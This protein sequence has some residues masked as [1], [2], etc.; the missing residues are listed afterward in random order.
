MKNLLNSLQIKTSVK[1]LSNFFIIILFLFTSIKA[2]EE[3]VHI[4]HL[5]AEEGL[6]L[7]QV[8]QIYQ[9]NLGFMWLGTY[10][11]LNRYDGYNFKVFLPEPDNIKSISSHDITSIF[12]DSKGILWI[13]T[14][15][16]LN[17]YDFKTESFKRYLHDANDPNSLSNNNIYSIMEDKSGT[18]WFGT[19]DALNKYNRNKD[20]FSTLKIRIGDKLVKTSTYDNVESISCMLQDYKGNLWIGIWDG[21]INMDSN[22]NILKQFI[23][24]EG[25]TDAIGFKSIS[26]I[27]EDKEKFIWIGTNGNG[28]YKYD[29]STG[30]FDHYLSNDSDSKTISYNYIN[31]IFQDNY[32]DIWIGT[33]NGLNKY[34]PQNNTFIRIFNNSEKP[35]SIINNEILSITQDKSG[36]IWIGSNGGISRFYKPTN[37]FYY[38]QKD[39]RVTSYSLSNN[40]IN[41]VFID[42]KENMLVGTLDGLDYIINGEKHIINYRTDPHNKNSISDNYITTAIEDRSGYRWVGTYQNGLNRINLR[43]GE[44]KIFFH[45][46]EN[47][48]SLSNSGITDLLEDHK[49][50]IWVGTWYGLNRYNKSTEKFLRYENT[51]D[52]PK[53][54]SNNSV[55]KIYEDSKNMIWVGTDGGGVCMM[56][57][58]ISAFTVY[59]HDSTN[60][61][62]ISNNRVLTITETKDGLMW[63]GTSDGLNSF[64][65]QTGKFK[66]FKK[67]NGL[68]G[69]LIFSLQEDN[70]GLL[71]ISTDNGIS[72]YN[73]GTGTFTNYSKKD[74]LKELEFIG[75]ASC[76]AKDGTL[77]FG[78]KKG[79]LFFNPNNIVNRFAMAPIIFTDLKIYNKSVPIR[80]NSNSIL[81]ESITTSTSIEIPS[82][83][84]EI[85]IDFALLYYQSVRG[86]TYQYILSGFE[87]NWN[88]AGQRNSATYANL[89]PGEY[90]FQVQAAN[91]DGIKGKNVA[92]L[93]IIIVPAYYQTWWFKIFLSCVFLLSIG[94]FFQQRTRKIK[95][96]NKILE[97]HVAERTKDLDHT[98][99]ELNRE[100]VERKKAEANVHATLE[101]KEGLLLEKEILLKEIHHRV[102]NN[103]QIISSLLYLQS[104]KI[105]DS[106]LL[107]MFD[108]SLNRIKSMALLHEKLYQSNDLSEINLF[109]YINSLL[110][111]LKKSYSRSDI[112]IRDSI[113]I[114]HDI[115]F[116]LDTAMAC[117]LMI[118]ELM[119]NAYKYAFPK[120]WIEKLT[121]VFEFKIEV[122]V[123]KEEN[124]IYSLIVSDNGIGFPENFDIENAESLGMKIVSSMVK[125]LDGLLEIKREN[126][127]QFKTS[128]SY[129]K[130]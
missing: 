9:D 26:S 64:D 72:C 18:L 127:S 4:S 102:K 53:C 108:D 45:E 94:L 31:V 34:N 121:S 48:T 110:T 103:L 82:E 122:S 51:V 112:L 73:R 59:M 86:N 13:G 98:I 35:L 76:K 6:S 27:Y 92:S 1:Q 28:L 58:K 77:Y 78:S 95:S 100:V 39:N 25:N 44:N 84:G 104:R 125:Q 106:E 124:N 66:V 38:F 97:N 70:N 23:Y 21:L 46:N 8:T 49:G 79:L 75:R 119:T 33:K 22:G 30:K 113:F 24:K 87:K 63:F 89:P 68:P 29:P 123:V 11:G 17:R 56:D 19:H 52:D 3:E 90:I 115:N 111:H 36:L 14:N 67:E 32:N 15:N 91:S 50:T 71:W 65:R 88:D 74:G 83:S 40:R 114:N 54:L 101:E 80:Q 109:N 2:Q 10:S 107:N 57:P 43:T 16:G 128:F 130:K 99:T 118:N 85:T 37:K 96:Q 12:Q 60:S 55:W 105:K 93:Q 20:N 69:N 7:S 61:N 116:N 120:V 129:H 81:K 62:P 47:T 126:G 117:G 42:K 5:T 41:S